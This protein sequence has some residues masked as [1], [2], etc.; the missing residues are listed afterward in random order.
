MKKLFTDYYFNNYKCYR[1]WRNVTWYKHEFTE[2][3]L[4]LSI[5]FVGTFWA[6]YGNINRYSK[7]IKTENKT[8]PPV[9]RSHQTTINATNLK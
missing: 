8:A 6:L 4:Y 1:K 2:D 5:T 7:V 3:A 9:E